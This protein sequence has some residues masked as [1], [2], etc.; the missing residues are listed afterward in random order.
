MS[1]LSVDI[2]KNKRLSLTE[3]KAP[4]PPRQTP[5]RPPTEEERIYEAM[6]KANPLLELLV[7][8]LNLVPKEVGDLIAPQEEDI[9]KLPLKPAPGFVLEQ[10][11]DKPTRYRFFFEAG[12]LGELEDIFIKGRNKK[13]P[14][15]LRIEIT[16]LFDRYK[17]KAPTESQMRELRNKVNSVN[18]II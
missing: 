14:I 18:K 8:K 7:D 17:R 5:G 1:L 2:D 9:D 13:Q 6:I 16:K 15:E 12:S 10:I 4:T 3:V 11:S